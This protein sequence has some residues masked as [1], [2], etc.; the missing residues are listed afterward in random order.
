MRNV[1]KPLKERRVLIDWLEGRGSGLLSPM[2]HVWGFQNPR[3]ASP[4]SPS[5]SGIVSLIS[6]STADADQN[7]PMTFP[8]PLQTQSASSGYTSKCV[9]SVA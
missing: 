5:A 1:L 9:R 8:T 2:T 3:I 6:L 4:A 7:P